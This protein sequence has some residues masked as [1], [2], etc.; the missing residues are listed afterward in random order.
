LE[1][2]SLLRGPFLLPGGAEATS[3]PEVTVLE[4][5]DWQSSK[6]KRCCQNAQE[7]LFLDKKTSLILEMSE[8]YSS[9]AEGTRTPNHRID[10]PVL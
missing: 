4:K 10:S 5:R 3:A 1:K 9:E 7:Y 2:E 8:V 6:R